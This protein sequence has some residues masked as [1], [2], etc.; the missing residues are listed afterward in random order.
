MEV[1][2]VLEVSKVESVVFL[3]KENSANSSQ[4]II[5]KINSIISKRGSAHL[6]YASKEDK[7]N[8]VR[9]SWR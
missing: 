4:D 8:G 6:F 2:Q 7:E 9:L 5:M 3:E 1:E